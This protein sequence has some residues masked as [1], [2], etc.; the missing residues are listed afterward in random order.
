MELTGDQY[1]VLAALRGATVLQREPGTLTPDGHEHW[2]SLLELAAEGRLVADL[3]ALSAAR[4]LY[5]RHLAAMRTQQ[6]KTRFCLTE[7]GFLALAGFEAGHGLTEEAA[8]QADL[9][10]AQENEHRARAALAAAMAEVGLAADRL[11][12]ARGQ[13]AARQEARS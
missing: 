1:R 6:G 8:A 4:G 10:Q 2:H 11:N 7:E 5:K 9:D 12:R 3:A 13:R